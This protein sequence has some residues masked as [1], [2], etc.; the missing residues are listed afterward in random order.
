MTPP[1]TGTSPRWLRLMADYSASGLWSPNGA[2]DLD[3]VPLSDVLKA[4][5]AAW[6][7]WYETNDDYLPPEARKG[8]FDLAAFAAE[9]LAIAKAIRQAL[10]D[11]TVVYYD[12]ARKHARPRGAPRSHFQ[13]EVEED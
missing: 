12:E 13:Y 8:T 7:A 1:K 10:P 6:A 5:V 2:L 11:W 4:R 3:D 9:G